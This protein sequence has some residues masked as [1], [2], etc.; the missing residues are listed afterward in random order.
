MVLFAALSLFF[1]SL[2]LWLHPQ[3]PPPLISSDPKALSPLEEETPVPARGHSLQAIRF[4]LFFPLSRPS[5]ILWEQKVVALPGFT[6][7]NGTMF[8]TFPLFF[9]SPPLWS[10]GRPPM[11]SAIANQVSSPIRNISIRMVCALISPF[12]PP[13]SP[14]R[15]W[16]SSAVDRNSARVNHSG[17]LKG[18]KK[19]K[20][21]RRSSLLLFPPPQPTVKYP[22]G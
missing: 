6:T 10:C 20:K 5:A 12:S 9:F 11:D 7:M 16:P 1:S 19:K 17:S 21:H 4:F 3:N 18:I 15:P 2:C 22:E 14:L 13:F 8:A